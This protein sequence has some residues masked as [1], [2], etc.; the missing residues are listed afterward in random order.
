MYEA[1][2]LDS[3]PLQLALEGGMANLKHSLD[4]Y[5]SRE[6][7]HALFLVQSYQKIVARQGEKKGENPGREG[8]TSGRKK[9]FTLSV[10]VGIIITCPTHQ[11]I[12]KLNCGVDW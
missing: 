9:R 10:T 7:N 8:D 12:F 1:R 6:V 2:R 4:T 11:A 5:A 3:L